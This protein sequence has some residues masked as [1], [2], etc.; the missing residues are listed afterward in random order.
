MF[1]RQRKGYA[2]LAGKRYVY[3][4]RFVFINDFLQI[5]PTQ[6]SLPRSTTVKL[7]F[8]YSEATTYIAIPIDVLFRKFW[9]RFVKQK[10]AYCRL[11]CQNVLH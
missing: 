1:P 4:K 2:L 10:I 9:V 8:D 5:L 3:C 6:I 11:A 7:Q